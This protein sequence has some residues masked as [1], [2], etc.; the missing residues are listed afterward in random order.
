[1]GFQSEEE[2]IQQSILLILGTALG[3]RVMRPT[4]GS[5]LSELAFAERS[6]QTASLAADYATEALVKW[7]PRIDV[8]RV[9]ALDDPADPGALQIV[10]ANEV[11]ATNS[12]FNL[13]YPF[14]LAEG[15]ARAAD[16]G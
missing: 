2:K 9:S 10:V 3:E 12:R 5:R 4:F 11:R 1:M 13:V 15:R 14:Y 16:A 6:A 7:E 8:Q